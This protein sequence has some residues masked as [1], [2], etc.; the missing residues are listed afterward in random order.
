[1]RT[2]RS[3]WMRIA[4]LLQRGRAEREFSAELDEHIAMH[5]DEDRRSGL[6]EAEAR[7][8]ALLK[9]GGAEQARQAY[10][11][12]ATLP[13]VETVFQ[14]VRYALR[15]FR[16]NPIFAVT[17]IV[18][19]A[20]GLGATM[21][22]FSV[23]DRILFRALPY[24]DPSRIV[25]LGFVHSLERQEFVMG[26][27]YVEWQRDQRPFSALAAQSTGVHNCDLV[28]EQSDATGLYF[29]PGEL[30]SLVW[31]LSRFSVAT[32][33]PKRIDPTDRAW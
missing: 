10:R 19:L 2:M 18:T 24:A 21:A 4:G 17:A 26:R 3:L 25:S 28:E 20:L 33:C 15:G 12:R 11:E 6:T 27:F 5:I 14:D 29:I 32:F 23:V 30:S 22:V 13:W 9:L 31:N 1:M 8:Q 16:R 7:R